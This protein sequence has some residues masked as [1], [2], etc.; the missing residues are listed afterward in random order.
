[1]NLRRLALAITLLSPVAARAQAVATPHAVA[2]ADTQYEA[3]IREFEAADRR[4]PPAPGGVLFV[5][6]SSIRKWESLAQDCPVAPPLNR[7]FGGA[8]LGDVL[9]YANRIVVPYRPRLIVLYAGDNDLAAGR[10][11]R[12]VYADYRAFVALVR[13]RLPKTRVV[14]VAV[15]PSIARWNIVGQI[16]AANALVRRYAARDPRHL[17]YVDVFTPMLGADGRPRPELFI[18]D[19]L[20]MTPAGYALW[21]SILRPYVR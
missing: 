8:Q 13:R 11:P 21:T 16:R 1:M 14:F 5:G 17:A 9:H 20:H 15:K 10:T 4:D 7:G 6:S 3:E 2:P 19:G 12:Q 18:D